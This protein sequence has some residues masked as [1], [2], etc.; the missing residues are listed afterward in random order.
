M[1]GEHIRWRH[2]L[3]DALVAQQLQRL[4]SGGVGANTLP[5]RAHRIEDGELVE[6]ERH[7]TRQRE[8]LAGDGGVR[9]IEEVVAEHRAAPS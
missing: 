4:A 1:D 5:A 2:E 9:E 3:E 6:I 8:L 7:D